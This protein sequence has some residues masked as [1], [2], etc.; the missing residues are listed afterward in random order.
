MRS[1]FILKWSEV[2]EVSEVK[3]RDWSEVSYGEVRVDNDTMYIRVPFY[4][5]HLIILWLFHLGIF[6]TV[7]ALICTVVIFYCF[8]MCVYVGG[9]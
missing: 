1:D 3:W 5:G 4:C 6:Y 9:L 2:S 7:F 8:V